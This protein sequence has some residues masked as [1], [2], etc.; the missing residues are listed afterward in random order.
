MPLAS[1]IAAEAKPMLTAAREI[2]SGEGCLWDD[3]V[4][5]RRVVAREMDADCLQHTR[6]RYVNR[7]ERGDAPGPES[8][9]FKLFGA[10]L[11]QRIVEWHQEVA[12][13]EVPVHG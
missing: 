7:V 3:P 11:I 12:G 8:M 5:R 1:L 10:E 13:P 9:I 2:S 6:S 4:L